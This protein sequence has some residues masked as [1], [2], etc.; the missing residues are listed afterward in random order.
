MPLL[1]L[2]A[3][4]L[5]PLLLLISG[6]AP[7]FAP[8]AAV[9][10]FAVTGPLLGLSVA[11]IIG[12]RLRKI[13][14]WL[15]LSLPLVFWASSV[16]VIL[17]AERSGLRNAA[18]LLSAFLVALYGWVLLRYFHF[19]LRYQPYSL[20]AV[21][22]AVSMATIFFVGSNLASL[23]TF[24]A[25]PLWT[26]VL[27]VFGLG[28]YLACHNFWTGKVH[29]RQALPMIV[30]SGIV[31]AEAFWV[32]SFLPV[33]PSVVGAILALSAYVATGIARH[34]YLATVTRRIAMRYAF[35]TLGGLVLV[36]GTARWV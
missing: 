10:V 29:T 33:S 18:A 8:R 28:A 14:N 9:A 20:A 3:C 13:E 32:A 26:A 22:Q 19:P 5:V 15:L 34:H 12:E 24:L 6:F 31:L 35:I 4:G 17:L 23:I 21:S 27:L 16:L 36:L 1:R 11:A 7:A 30:G 25:M 2:V